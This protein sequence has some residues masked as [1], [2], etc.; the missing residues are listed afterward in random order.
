MIIDYIIS[1]Y[2]ATFTVTFYFLLST[3]LYIEKKYKDDER[4]IRVID[5]YQHFIV[6][7]FMAL[8]LGPYLGISLLNINTRYKL[9]RNIIKIKRG[10][11]DNQDIP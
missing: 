6:S 1:Y 10:Y 4:T 7:L 5:P 2:L 9:I 11:H 3:A 8:F